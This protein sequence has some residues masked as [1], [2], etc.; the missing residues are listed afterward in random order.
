M[1][2]TSIEDNDGGKAMHRRKKSDDGMYNNHRREDNKRVFDLN[3]Q[4]H[5]R[6]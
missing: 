6:S 5:L 4:M 2:V 3:K 1:L